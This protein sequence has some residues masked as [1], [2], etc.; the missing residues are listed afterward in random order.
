MVYIFIF[1]YTI[2]DASVKHRLQEG[3]ETFGA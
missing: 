2:L 3:K 1:K